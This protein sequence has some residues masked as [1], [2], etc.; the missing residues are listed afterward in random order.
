MSSLSLHLNSPRLSA[1]LPY[2]ALTGGIVSLSLGTSFAKSLYPM[3]GAA[4]TASLRVGLSA[5]ILLAIWRPWRARL[6][7]A[8]LQG[9]AIYG[10]VMGLMN[11][12]F[13]MSLATIPLGVALAIEFTGPLTIALLNSR[14]LIHFVW[15]GFAVLGLALLL[16]LDGNVQA[17][18]PV[19]CAFAA[20]AAL[21]W[22][23]YIVF[24]KRVSHLPSGPTVAVGMSMAALTVVPFGV[25]TAGLKLL[26]PS[27]LILGLVVAVV[28]SALPYTLD[29]IALKGIPKRTFGVMLSGDPAVGALAGLLFLGEHLSGLQWLAIA[30]II[31]ASIGAVLTSPAGEDQPLQDPAAPA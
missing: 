6:T 2:L 30:A 25:A 5:L 27:I 28:S 29:M 8:D 14:K 4:G 17:L 22:A 19:G 12:C 7:R 26:E 15:I 10:V 20:A 21:F 23:L 3:V 13:Y 18:D 1:A 9:L 24:G 31:T 11:L 16:P